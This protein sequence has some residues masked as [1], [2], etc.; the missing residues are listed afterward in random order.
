MD[1]TDRSVVVTGGGNG[2]GLALARRF[3]EGGA[4]GVVIADLNADWAQRAARSIEDL[5]VPALGIACDVGDPDAISRLADETEQAF[6]SIDVFCSNAGFTDRPPS[7]LA[8][9]VEQWRSIVDVNML[10]HVWAAQR[11]VPAMVERGVGYLLQT[12]SA[13]G[14]ITGPAPPGYSMTKH[15]ALGFA[16][17]LTLNYG[18]LGL[19]VSCLCPGPVYTGLFGRT[20]DDNSELPADSPLGDILTPEEVADMVFAAMTG[21]EPFLILPHPRVGESFARK[22]ADYDRWIEGT[23]RRLQRMADATS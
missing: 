13:T 20:P 6:G 23:R 18:H 22:A 3:A 17:W 4:R 12:V 21:D 5:G 19:R 7:D 1:L 8:Q 16:E 15:G 2:I 11:V 14:L 9:A 10:S